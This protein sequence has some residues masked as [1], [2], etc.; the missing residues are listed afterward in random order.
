MKVIDFTKASEDERGLAVSEAKLLSEFNHDNVL[1]YVDSFMAQGALCLVT[2]YCEGG[3]MSQ[4]LAKRKGRPLQES[5][6][7]QFFQ[8][9]CSGL[10][11]SQ[12]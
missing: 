1:Q 2:E 12:E 3:D 8:N 6:L 11:V 9:T 4:F 5:L 7:L 10:A